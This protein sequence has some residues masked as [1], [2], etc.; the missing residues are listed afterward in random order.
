M[1]IL[2]EVSKDYLLPGGQRLR[3]LD[4]I[5]FELGDKTFNSV[6]GPSGCG[7]STILNLIAGLDN[8]SSGQISIDGKKTGFVFQQPRLLNWRTVV[9]NVILPLEAD[10]FD[11]E[12]RRQFAFKYL[13][14]VG[15][16]GYED[17][18]PLQLSGGMQQRVAIA[19]A[20][21][22]EPD[23]LLM[24]EPFSGLDELT[25]R[26]LRQE[27]V[28]IWQETGKTILFV[29]H[30]ISEAVF[31]SQQILIV[32]QKPARIFKR[33]TIEAPYPRQYGDLRLFEIETDLTKD[34][35]GMD[36]WDR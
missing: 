16:G 9:D 36:S 30:S 1:I 32:T 22:I 5:S 25:A 12:T 24:D 6:L 13:R 26:K 2:K 27:L 34:F 17:Y 18:F 7:K 23:I 35:L 4:K 28:R 20:L 3:V 31:L 10:D 15:L 11:K 29:T 21:V 19:R 14:L 33:I 8:H